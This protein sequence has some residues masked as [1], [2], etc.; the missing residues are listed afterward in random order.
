MLNQLSLGAIAFFLLALCV[1][2]VLS[3]VIIFH[4]NRYAIPGDKTPLARRIFYLGNILFF[5]LTIATLLSF[6]QKQLTG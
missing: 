6:I 3:T 5:F 1:F 2:A 4:L